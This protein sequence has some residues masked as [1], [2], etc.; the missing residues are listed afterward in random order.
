MISFLITLVICY[1]FGIYILLFAIGVFIKL[2]PYI[3]IAFAIL[4]ILAAI[5]ILK[6][7]KKKK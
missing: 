4:I 7:Y 3:K 5:K 2:W 6:K 1:Y